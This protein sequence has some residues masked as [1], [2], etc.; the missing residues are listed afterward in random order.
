M[1]CQ[2]S[3]SSVAVR[4][5]SLIQIERFATTFKYQVAR[6]I[7]AAGIRGITG[8]WTQGI[9]YH[10]VTTAPGSCPALIG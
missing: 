1:I 7:L 3:R 8:E 6:M 4:L 5:K 9:G 2:E 10:L